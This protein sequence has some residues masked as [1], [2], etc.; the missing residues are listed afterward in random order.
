MWAGYMPILNPYIRDFSI[1]DFGMGR[2]VLELIPQGYRE[3]T[4]LKSL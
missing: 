3:A 4:I 1:H 2:G